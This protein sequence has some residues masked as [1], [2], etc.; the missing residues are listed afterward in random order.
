M[1]TLPSE[2]LSKISCY[3]RP[4]EKA[5]MAQLNHQVKQ[6]VALS[7]AI[8]YVI[9]SILLRESWESQ[10]TKKVH[11]LRRIIKF[12]PEY[13][14][15][16]WEEISSIIC[17]ENP[18][19]NRGLYSIIHYM[20][21][22]TPMLRTLSEAKKKENWASSS[23]I[24]SNLCHYELYNLEKAHKHMYRKIAPTALA[25]TDL[26]CLTLTNNLQ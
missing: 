14:I 8:P 6:D 22:M 23:I 25:I 10:E 13:R 4:K 9:Y 26:T 11:L 18:N 7:S 24:T 21:F 3:L 1:D 15:K 2:I 5:N 12:F 16:F 17:G 20:Y 19:H